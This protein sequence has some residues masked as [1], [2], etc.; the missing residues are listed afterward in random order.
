M[1]KYKLAVDKS[2]IDNIMVKTSPLSI[3]LLLTVN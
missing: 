2:A 1:L 3:A